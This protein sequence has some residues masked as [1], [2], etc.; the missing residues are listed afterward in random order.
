MPTPTNGDRLQQTIAPLKAELKR[1]LEAVYGSNLRGLYL[2]GSH[3]RGQADPESDF[4][5][6]IVLHDLRDY[7][8]EI[9]RTG[10]IIAELSLKYDVSI[11][12]VRVRDADWQYQDSPFLNEVRREAVAL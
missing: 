11:S 6:V 10:R 4:D 5:I 9:Q 1:E 3:A 2:Y 8:E 12:P 7:W